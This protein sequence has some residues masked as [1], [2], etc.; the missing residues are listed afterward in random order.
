[1]EKILIDETLAA[2]LKDLG[3]PA[4]LCTAQGSVVGRF[5][6]LIDLSVWKPVGPEI[7]EEELSRRVAYV[8]PCGTTEELLARLGQK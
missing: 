3:R 2:K 8:G 6:P 4:E 7:S 5:V 1:M